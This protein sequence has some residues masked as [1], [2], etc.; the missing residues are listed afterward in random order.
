MITFRVFVVLCFFSFSCVEISTGKDYSKNNL[1]LNHFTYRWRLSCFHTRVL[2]HTS[3]G[4][5]LE[6]HG[7]YNLA[8]PSG[9]TGKCIKERCRAILRK[10][11]IEKLL[12]IWCCCANL[13]PPPPASD[14]SLQLQCWWLNRMQSW[15]QAGLFICR[16]GAEKTA[17]RQMHVRDRRSHLRQMPLIVGLFA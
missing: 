14:A 4:E 15:G 7:F 11:Q 16:P 6:S 17:Q 10:M 9:W 8:T 13:H 12:V 2:S 1:S 3:L 5:C